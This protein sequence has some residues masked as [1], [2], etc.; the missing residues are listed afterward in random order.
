MSHCALVD[1]MA[2]F[3]DLSQY[4]YVNYRPGV[5][6]LNVGWLS[7]AM[8]FGKKKATDALLDR[9][10]N[11]CALSFEETR[12]RHVCEFC[13]EDTSR[14]AERLG[15]RLHLGSA[16]I[17]VLSRSGE[18]YAAPNLIYHYMLA[19]DYDPPEAFVDALL[20]GPLVTSL[21][22][23]DRLSAV[24]LVPRPTLRPRVLGASRAPW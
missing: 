5:P 9:V 20:T 23:V 11:Y 21:E 24:G 12:G 10:W 1:A 16:E 15:Q 17:R 3:P 6:E 13:P 7:A 18:I 19:H 14:V 4:R 8:E 22:Y 2:Y